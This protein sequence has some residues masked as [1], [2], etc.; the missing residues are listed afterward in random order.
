MWFC[1][2]V[3]RESSV[4][5]PN[6]WGHTFI[7]RG[8]TWLGLTTCTVS[9][10]Q[11]SSDL[12]ALGVLHIIVRVRLEKFPIY[13]VYIPAF[14]LLTLKS[15]YVIATVMF[16]CFRRS[17]AQGRDLHDYSSRDRGIY[18]TA[19]NSLW[20]FIHRYGELCWQ[21]PWKPKTRTK[22]ERL[23]TGLNKCLHHHTFYSVGEIMDYTEQQ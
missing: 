2:S 15:V 3:V 5:L 6:F 9:L 4:R 8:V 12:Y 21:T 1:S 19:Q 23:F 17:L 18:R 11:K 14:H 22:S 13:L 7:Y 16:C 20:Q 10:Y